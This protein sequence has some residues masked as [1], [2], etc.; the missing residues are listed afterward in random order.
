MS[1]RKVFIRLIVTGSVMGVAFVIALIAWTR[2]DRALHVATGMTSWIICTESFVAGLPPERAYAEEIATVPGMRR[3]LKRLRYDVDPVGKN[4]TTTWAGHFSSTAQF[5]PGRGCSLPPK[6]SGLAG[7]A[8]ETAVTG[9]R[10]TTPVL[11]PTDPALG[12]ALDHAFAES[13]VPPLK[14]VRAVVVMKDGKIIAERYAPGITVDTPLLSYSVAKSVTNAMLG[15]LV[16]QGK[17]DMMKPAPVPAWRASADPRNAITPDQLLRMES[18]LDFPEEASGFDPVSRM[19]FIEP[20][21][22]AFAAAAPLLAPPGTRWDYSSG[23]TLIL[24]GIVRDALGG[25]AEDVLRFARNELFE[26][27]GIRNMTFRFDAADAP[28]GAAHFMAPARDWARFGQMYLDNGKAPNGQRILPEGWIAYST[29]PTLGIDYGAGFWINRSES[30][31]ALGRVRAGMP[32]DTFY[33]SGLYGQRIVIIPSQ[34][35]V[36]VRFGATIGMPGDDI[37]G[38][39]RLVREVIAATSTPLTPSS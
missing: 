35:L 24:D 12:A 26:P 13:A 38:L 9:L 27:L 4:V 8:A 25:H 1:A 30:A 10:E 5:L 11:E 39:T 7:S 20:D 32:V 2:P 36:I 18:G 17:L 3:L 29:T 37:E 33:A 28:V 16:R 14:Q 6:V 22:A 21:M 15:V 23:S 34:Q 31:H 19:L